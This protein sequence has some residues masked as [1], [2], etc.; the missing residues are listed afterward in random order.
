M[1]VSVV[2]TF[3]LVCLLGCFDTAAAAD[4]DDDDDDTVDDLCDVS[5]AFGLDKA[6]VSTVATMTSL[7]I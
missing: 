1:S 6:G 5:S 2:T 3:S 7:A 4:D